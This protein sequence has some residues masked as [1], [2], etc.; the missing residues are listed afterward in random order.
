MTCVICKRKVENGEFCTY[1][2]AAHENL[3]KSY[4]DWKEAY[5]DLTFKEYLKKLLVNKQTGNWVKEVA[6]YL[7]K[8]ESS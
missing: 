6:N 1:H 4:A 7:L 5:G 2:N 3:Q 8:K